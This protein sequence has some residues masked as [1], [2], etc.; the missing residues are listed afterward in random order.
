MVLEQF[1]VLFSLLHLDFCPLHSTK[2]PLVNVMR[3]SWTLF[4][5]YLA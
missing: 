3:I 2:I 4:N 5:P 1:Y